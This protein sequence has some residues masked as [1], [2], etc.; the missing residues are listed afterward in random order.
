MLNSTIKVNRPPG[1]PQHQLHLYGL[2]RL[3]DESILADDYVSNQMLAVFMRFEKY[4]DPFREHAPLD[5]RVLHVLSALPSEVQQDFL[6]DDRF[7]VILDNYEKGKGWSLV[8]DLPSPKGD[9]SRC[10]V[11]KPKL[12]GCD[13]SFA[14]YVIAHE[15]AHAYLRNG[16][17]GEITDREQAADALAAY[18][19]FAR[20][21]NIAGWFAR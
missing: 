13:E 15:F 6:D 11:L 5:A 3:I 18:W 12:A 17:W 7:H 14:W 1:S 16:G 2:H 20:P 8:M 21:R 10:V 19:G 4:I 9:A